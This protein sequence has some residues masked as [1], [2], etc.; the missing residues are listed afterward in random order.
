MKAAVCYEFDKPLS[1]EEVEID[2][3][4]TGEV[5]VKIAACAI[6]HSD[7]HRIRGGWCGERPVVAGHEA[8]GI[9]TQVGS[10]VSKVQPGD[11]VVVSLLRS[12]SDC[13][14]CITGR[15][16]DCEAEF[17]LDRVSTLQRRG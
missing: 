14:S 4:Q 1:V 10:G 11:Q 7:I 6:C 13:F 2:R 9:V 5:M 8:A 15:L 17:A 16:Y 12:C 3:P